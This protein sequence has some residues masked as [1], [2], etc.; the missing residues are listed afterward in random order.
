MHR[1]ILL[2][3]TFFLGIASIAATV[4]ATSLE[5][6]AS[7]G[8]LPVHNVS[9]VLRYYDAVN[10]MIATG[11]P[12]ALR[13][14]VHPEMMDT[15]A[16]LAGPEGREGI[17]AYLSHLH[18]TMP[19]TRLVAGP[20]AGDAAQVIAQ[21]RVIR[22]SPSLSLGFSMDR[23]TL[24]WPSSEVFRVSSGQIIER[25]F[26]WDGL[27]TINP[28]DAFP[29]SRDIPD[30]RALSV[31]LQQYQGRANGKFV[32]AEMPAV[33]GLVS[34]T[35]TLSLSRTA[36]APAIVFQPPYDGRRV[37]V[38]SCARHDA[39]AQRR[40]ASPYPAWFCLFDA[41]PLAGTGLGAECVSGGRIRGRA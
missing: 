24:V 5:R 2:L 35:I 6:P 15:T 16:P 29:D 28:L 36:T 17:E 20:V 27:V 3:A 10:A 38:R 34:G 41:Q 31:A 33:L 7:S 4:V 32:T 19:D 23:P 13:E 40:R 14:V 39:N 9:T 37:P 22:A 11:D 25:E 12:T 21:V 26:R 8:M 18:A 1:P 30:R